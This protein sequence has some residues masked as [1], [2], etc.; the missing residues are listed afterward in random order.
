MSSSAFT[1]SVLTIAASGSSGSGSGEI[2]TITNSSAVIDASGWTNATR[3]TS[4]SPL[5]PVISTAFA[6]ANTAASESS[7]SGGYTTFTLP[8]G[9]Q[10][11]KLKVEFYFTT[12][13]TDVYAVSVYKSTTRV[14]LST[15]SSSVT[16]LPASTTGKFTAYFDTDTTSGWT[17]SITRTSG[18]TGT[19]YITQV[20]VGPGIQSQGAVVGEWQSYTPTLSTNPWGT[21][22]ALNFAKYR[23]VG[24]SL[25]IKGR[26][27]T[28]TGTGANLLVIPLPS[29]LNI[30]HSNTDAF[31]VGK[32]MDTV[33]STGVVIIAETGASTTNLYFGLD[34]S[35]NAFT[36]RNANDFGDAQ[37][38]SWN[39]VIE[40]AEWAG[41]GTVN[42]AQNDVEWASNDGSGGTSAGATYN[43]GM[44]YG[45]TGSTF[46]GV[47]ST[48]ANSVTSYLV[49]FQTPR[50][51][52]DVIT[53][54]VQ[55][56]SG[57]WV[58]LGQVSYT[59]V[60]GYQN[61]GDSYY[62]IGWH[63]NGVSSATDIYVRFGNKGSSPSGTNGAAFAAN[64]VA[65]AAGTERW[66]VRKSSAG[67]AV[68][69]GIADT[70]SNGLVPSNTYSQGTQTW[71]LQG[72]LKLPTSGGTKAT[73]NFYEELSQASS[74]FTFSGSGSNTA[75][76]TLRIY[77]T[78]K[79]VTIKWPAI[80]FTSSNGNVQL[81]SNLIPSRFRPA[82]QRQWIFIQYTTGGSPAAAPG[83]VA[84]DTGGNL[85]FYKDGTAASFNSGTLIIQPGDITFIVD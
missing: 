72:G 26:A 12:P 77:R 69:F 6:I 14:P 32:G 31:L 17:V 35:I 65:W 49:R 38:L 63:T 20:I 42:L 44:V 53:I 61:Q 78:G 84:L 45:P 23:R 60:R 27:I 62:G 2:N 10:N 41:S 66:R 22:A 57:E 80:S 81:T 19:C 33:S 79:T 82:E 50:Q 74:V 25:E 73:L 46:V 52:S 71:D 83:M 54:E 18:S 4:N 21:G 3:V 7:T 68:G 1:P 11:K 70:T 40:I 29:G 56:N 51:I 48:T 85:Q 16:T 36:K 58:P 47:A 24:S 55:A 75:S 13:A 67:A 9:L 5:N 15:D 39:A 37:T 30:T 8:T 28:G 34:S 64:G 43:T 59:A 76:V